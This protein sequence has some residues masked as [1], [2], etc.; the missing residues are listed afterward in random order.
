MGGW[1]SSSDLTTFISAILWRHCRGV[2]GYPGLYCWLICRSSGAWQKHKCYIACEGFAFA[3][4]MVVDAA[5]VVLENIYRHPELGRGRIEGAIKGASEVWGAI[6]ASAITTVVVFAPI[7]VMDL[8]VGQLFRDIA[9]ALSVAVILSLLV[10][11]TVVPALAR[12][13]LG[14]ETDMKT[15]KRRLPII[16]PASS[17]F[18]SFICGF[19]KIT[20]S[21]RLAGIAVVASVCGLAGY[22]TWLFLP[23]LFL[24][25]RWKQKFCISNSS[26][27][28][29]V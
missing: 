12:R 24:P 1:H 5:I 17:A 13:L 16:D 14:D 7:L 28:S 9:I 25:T 18:A 27:T 29:W 4:G 22:G 19:T 8:V 2:C 21:S 23:K 20:I 26:D 11:I 3:V 6:M 10:S 15:Q